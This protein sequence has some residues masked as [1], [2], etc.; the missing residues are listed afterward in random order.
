MNFLNKSEIAVG[1]STI[2]GDMA[3]AY[4]PLKD[5][6]KTKVYDLCKWRNTTSK[7]NN[8]LVKKPI[9]GNILLKEPPAELAFDQKDTDSLPNYDELD[10]ILE[11]LIEDDLS[12]NEVIE[13]SF[14]VLAGPLANIIFAFL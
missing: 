10:S 4:N 12:I 1:Y 7:T 14:V 5:V 3:G 13:K 2:Y 9:P 6:Y 8:F 11:H